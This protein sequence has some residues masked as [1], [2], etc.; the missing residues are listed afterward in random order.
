MTPSPE[1]AEIFDDS[2]AEPNRFAEVVFN[3]PLDQTFTYSIPEH[4]T[5]QV[6]PGMR[7]QVSFGAGKQTGYVV[8][9]KSDCPPGIKLKP[10]QAAPDGEPLVSAHMLELTRWVADY[11]QAGWGEVIRT[12]LPAGLEEEVPEVFCLTGQGAEKLETG[13]ASKSEWLLLEALSGKSKRTAKQLR[14]QLGA[15]F[16]A[17]T[18]SRLRETGDISAALPLPKSSARFK[19]QK[20]ARAEEGVTEE[21]ADR[22]LARARK[23]KDLYT[24]I[25]QNP[26]P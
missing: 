9:L 25:R 7:V 2:P 17:P 11:Y 14:R 20:I 26:G 3:L 15:H 10:V 18:L 16:S 6:Q 12:A 8:G 22:R 21:E 1:Q 13:M 24:L 19:V 4:L 23:Q 5:G